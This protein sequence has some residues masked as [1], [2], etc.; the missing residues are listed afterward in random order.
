MCSTSKRQAKLKVRHF[1][2]VNMFI[3]TSDLLFLDIY[4]GADSL[5]PLTES[6]KTLNQ[7]QE[8]QQP[9]QKQQSCQHTHVDLVIGL[10]ELFS[11]RVFKFIS[12]LLKSS[13]ILSMWLCLI[14]NA[15]KKKKF[16]ALNNQIS[17]SSLVTPSNRE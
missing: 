9:Y 12:D 1:N 13:L 5:R 3:I 15:W 14:S 7:H 4:P 10:C 6:M 2:S 8:I 16:T 17:V 11:C